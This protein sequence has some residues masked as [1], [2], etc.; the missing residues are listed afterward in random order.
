MDLLD[1]YLHAVRFCLPQTHQD[2]IVRELSENL[3]S[4]IEDR[5]EELGR[6][7]TE[8]EV[9]GILR[10]HGHPIIVAAK[11]RSGQQLIGPVFFPMYLFSLQL[12]LGVSLLITAILGAVNGVLHGDPVHYGVQAMLQY[13]G[14]GLMVFAWTTLGFAALDMAQARLKLKHDWDPRNL[15]RVVNHEYHISRSRTLCELCFVCATL[16]WL[17]LLPRMPFLLLGPAASAVEPAAIWPLAY[18]A[19]VLLTVATAMLHVVNFVR[20]YWTKARSLSR[21]GIHAASVLIFAV[22]LRAGEWFVPISPG[23]MW[24]GVPA[25]RLAEILNA[26]FQIGFLVMAIIAAIEALRELHRLNV[27]RQASHT[28]DSAV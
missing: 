17:L 26:S 25:E 21:V 24:N 18:V 11:Y 22:I 7:L 12:G 9:A 28:V 13:P 1:R 20:P 14:R 4:Q 16:V 23:T 6:P 2:D 27:R 19:I 10:R 5:Q 8:E 3:I 15:P